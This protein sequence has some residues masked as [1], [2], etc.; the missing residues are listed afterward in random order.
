MKHLYLIGGTM[1][2]GKTHTCQLLK[3]KLDRSVFLDGDWCWDAHPFQV[4]EETKSMVLDNIT[5]LLHNFLRCS[6]YEHVIF[7]WVMHEQS[8]IDTLVD[9]LR[10]QGDLDAA[11]L[12]CISLVCTPQA[13]EARLRRDV[14][15]GARKEEVIVRSIARLPL[16]QKLHTALLDVSDLTPAAAAEAIREGALHGSM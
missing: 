1:G 12:H 13:L 4:T 10:R 7:C 9:R 5:Y 16:Y 8:I 15:R 14:A 2:V 6:A 3:E 11:A